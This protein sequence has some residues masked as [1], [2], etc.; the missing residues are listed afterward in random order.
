MEFNQDHEF[1]IAQSQDLVREA[2][3]LVATTAVSIQA[4]KI[5]IRSTQETVRTS[6]ER[7]KGN[8]VIRLLE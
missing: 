5:M 4:M 3:R 8:P 6:R 7:L 1:L 2:G